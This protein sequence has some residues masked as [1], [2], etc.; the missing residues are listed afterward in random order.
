MGKSLAMRETGCLGVNVL[1]STTVAVREEPGL[2]ALPVQLCV[3]LCGSLLLSDAVVL[4]GDL[5]VHVAIA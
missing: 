4:L 5:S 1:S 2:A 3:P